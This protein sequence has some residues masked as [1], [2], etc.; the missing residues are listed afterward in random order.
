MD[1][2]AITYYATH[3]GVHAAYA[4]AGAF[5]GFIVAHSA[6]AAGL[7]LDPTIT[8]LA[9]GFVGTLASRLQAKAAPTTPVNPAP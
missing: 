5:L 6:D 8:T 4:A 3:T 1:K 9:L 7:G 2:K